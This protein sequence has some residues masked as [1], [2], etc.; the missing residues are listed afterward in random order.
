MDLSV[1]IPTHNPHLGRLRATLAALRA[2]TLPPKHWET[3]LVDNASQ[4]FPTPEQLADVAPSH[5]RIV[6]AP[7]LGLSAAR[8]AGIAAASGA[9][10]VFVD[11]DNVLAPDYLAQVLAIFA[12]HS[13]LG[14]AGGRSLPSFESPASSWTHEFFPLL[15]LRDLGPEPMVA[16]PAPDG[17]LAYPACAPI[18]AGMAARRDALQAWLARPTGL[19]DRRG[20]ELTSAGDNDIVLCAL[21]AGWSVGYFPQLCL[22]HLIPASRLTI[23]YLARLNRGIQRSWMQVLMLHGANSWPPISSWTLPL[24]RLKAWCSHP[25]WLGPE[26]RVRWH[27]ACGHFEGRV[28][29]S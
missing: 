2:Q 17:A 23:D 5:F 6:S 29:S 24:R 27:G 28:R 12:D 26:D 25:A 20:R 14:L 9:I 3:L 16:A 10:I 7:E 18:G 15:A 22:T 8:R 4:S 11:D 19:S 13:R 21:R 1:V